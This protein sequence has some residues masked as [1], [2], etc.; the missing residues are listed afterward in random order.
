MKKQLKRIISLLLCLCMMM[1]A[2]VSLASCGDD[3]DATESG[4]GDGAATEPTTVTALRV[5]EAMNANERLKRDHMQ[6]VQ[7]ST[8]DLPEGAITDIKEAIGKYLTVNVVAGEYVL[9]SKL[10]DTK[11]VGSTSTGETLGSEDYIVVTDYVKVGTDVSAKLQELIDNNPNKTL[12]FPDGIYR[13]SKSVTTPS[14]PT[15]TVSFRLSNYA[16]LQAAS[17]YTPVDGEGMIR[18]G[19]GAASNNK[20]TANDAGSGFYFMGGIV[21]MNGMGGTAISVEGGRN[22][23]INN[24]AI[25]NSDVGIHIKT[26]YVDVD[27]GVIAGSGTDKFKTLTTIGVRVDGSYNTVTNMRICSITRGI[28]LTEGNNVLRNLHPLYTTTADPE[29]AGFWDESAGN[30]YDYCYSD[31]FA[32]GFHLA[33]DN[34]SVLNGCFAF[35]YSASPNRHWGI[36]QNGEFNS[37]VRNTRIDMCQANEA[38]NAYIWVETAGGQG[39]I[40][41]ALTSEGSIESAYKSMYTT[42]KKT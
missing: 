2:L 14:D 29:S 16:I 10:S 22:V 20:S 4:S 33:A 9:A 37:V 5:V 7:V 21:D 6:E 27:S 40:V 18:L 31:N 15:K 19:A 3:A 39:I 38:D 24:F 42:Y 41:D 11:G 32:I 8:A 30:F 35:W 34:V 36:R 17:N 28:M 12:Y 25:R 26:D 13:F 1:G 23:L